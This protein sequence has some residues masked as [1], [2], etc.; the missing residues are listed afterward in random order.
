[1][2][3]LNFEDIHLVSYGLE[4][5]ITNKEGRYMNYLAKLAAISLCMTSSFCYADE[6]NISGYSISEIRNA[7]C[8]GKTTATDV[9]KVWLEQAVNNDKY[10]A[11]ASFNSEETLAMAKGVDEQVLN[12]DCKMLSGVPIAIKD[13]IQ[14][15]GFKNS[16]GTKALENFIPTTNANIVQK[17]VSEG[18]IVLGKTSMHELAFGT[19]GYNPNYA[20][21]DVVGV[22]NAFDLNKIPGGSSSGSGAAIGA[23]LAPIALGTDTGGSVRIPCALNGCV[24]FRPTTGRY[25]AEGVIPISFSRDTPGI[26]ANSVEDVMLVDYAISGNNSYPKLNKLKLGMPSYYWSD[27]DGD[28]KTATAIAIDKLRDSGIEIV[29]IEMPEIGEITNSFGMYVALKE[30]KESII[31]YLIEENT[32]VSIEDIAKN[33]KSPDVYSIMNDIVIPGQ[34]MDNT[35][36]SLSLDAVYFEGI[37]KK[38]DKLLRMFEKA[39]EDNGLDAIV[40]PTT[41]AVAGDS[42]QN[43]SKPENFSKYIRNTDPGS[44]IRMPGIT[45]PAGLGQKSNL[46]VGLALDALPGNDLKLLAIAKNVEEILG[47]R[48]YPKSE[49]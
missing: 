15:K 14:V 44:N 12:N 3:I 32:N 26:M 6:R 10:N 40:F 47:P 37:T 34:I 20:N 45:L 7:V 27:L 46:P 18:S 41:I 43:A 1:M 4:L 21:G 11:F 23:G 39:F 5:I 29:S 42:N 24:G 22:K 17:L 25:S 31:Q 35:G 28:V 8:A 2:N 33:I 13:N 9:A 16:G 30:A 19:S 36:K 38:K 49:L 48:P